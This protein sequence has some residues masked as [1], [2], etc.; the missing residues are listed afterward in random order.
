M[1]AGK[2]DKDKRIDKLERQLM[3]IQ[4]IV[5][6]LIAI[7]KSLSERLAKYE[8]PKNSS[9]SSIPPSKDENRPVKSKNLHE[10]SGKKPGGQPGHEGKTLEMTPAPMW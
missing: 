4:F 5:I 7:N 1:T 8:N 2:M 3:G 10:V 9:N 6:E